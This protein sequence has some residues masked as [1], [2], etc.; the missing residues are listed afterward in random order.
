MVFS[1][2]LI[3]TLTKNNIQHIDKV[4]KNIETYID[5][6]HT[7]F[8]TKDYEV[9][10]VDGN[11]TDGTYEVL[12][13]WCETQSHEERVDVNKIVE[14]QLN[15]DMARPLMLEQARNMYLSHFES[16]FEKG[17][18]LL[19]LDADEVNANPV[20]IKGFLSNFTSSSEWDFMG[21]NQSKEYYDIWALR[22]EGRGPSSEGCDYDCWRKVRETGDISYV[23]RHHK[24]IPEDS[25]LIEV[26]SAFGGTGI[27][28][29]EKL[30][31]LIYKSF[32]GGLEQCEHVSFNLELH[33]KGGK[34]YINPAFI[35]V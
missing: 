1:R 9:Y 13:K 2:L 6:C 17:T 4:L 24:N 29:T 34:L 25:E 12:K 20:N 10:F 16:K 3:A 19:I 7:H 28:H 11:S 30:K 5:L 23:N 27:Y 18:Y 22:K 14:Q 33:Q 26:K 35:N 8:S 21:A 15:T 32:V 31:G